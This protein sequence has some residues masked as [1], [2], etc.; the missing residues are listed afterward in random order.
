MLY[1][2]SEEPGITRFDPRPAAGYP[3]PVVWAVDDTHL[4][5]YLL[6]R[7]C[8]RVTFFVG[9]ST[10]PR[11]IDRFLGSSTAVVAFEASWL[12]RVRNT[13]LFRYHLPDTTFSC[14]DRCAGYFHSTHAVIPERVDLID[15]LLAAVASRNVEFRVLPSLWHL[16]DAVVA[17]TLGYSI[18]RMRNATPRDA[19]DSPPPA[20]QKAR[21]P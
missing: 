9:T 21:T 12:D 5:N 20:P 14:V 10:E 8:P 3:D 17:S 18:I 7:D 6:P 13:R 19:A 2:I 11:D 1:H 16:H 4:R 15:D